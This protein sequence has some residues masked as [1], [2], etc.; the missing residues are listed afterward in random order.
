MVKVSLINIGTD[1]KSA[2]A[3]YSIEFNLNE[4]PKLIE[5][6]KKNLKVVK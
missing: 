4:E 3:V 1:Y 6:Y 2:P 5:K